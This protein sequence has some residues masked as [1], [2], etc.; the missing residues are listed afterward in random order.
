MKRIIRI[1]ITSVILNMTLSML[2]YAGSPEFARPAEEWAH[3]RDNTLEWYEIPDLVKEYN[4]AVLQ[5]EIK[6]SSDELS[7]KDA[8]RTSQYLTDMAGEYESLAAD[9][10]GTTGGAIQAASLRLMADQ[11]R[12]Q[13]NDNTGDS[14]TVRYEY[15]RAEAQIVKNVKLLFISY[16]K[17]LL[18]AAFNKSNTAYLEQAYN[19]AVNRKNHGMSTEL[20]VLTALESLQNAKAKELTDAALLN[21]DYKKLITLCGWKYD[22]QAVIGGC[23]GMD[24]DAL[25]SIDAA[26]DREKA[27]SNSITL[28][29]DERKLKNAQDYYGYQAVQK[30][31]AQLDMDRNTVI[32]DFTSAY[33]DLALAKASYDSACAAASLSASDLAKAARQLNLGLI[34]RMEY[35]AAEHALTKAENDREMARLELLSKKAEYDALTEGLS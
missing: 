34:S 29:S 21:A 10:E 30:A 25:A 33:S 27:L 35:A 24:I 7:R 31:Q 28:K 9:M 19:S 18:Q 15:D 4:A 6:F 26:A 2:A 11:L 8:F 5:N 12:S 1:I 3:L 32:S 14:Q 22:S 16:Q 23:P 20:D 17:D 13:A